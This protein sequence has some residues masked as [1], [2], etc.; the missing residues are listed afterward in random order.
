[1]ENSSKMKKMNFEIIINAPTEKVYHCMLDRPTYKQWTAAFNPTSDYEGSWEKGSDIYFV[2]TNKKGQK[3]GMISRI[4]EN[5]PNKFVS[6]EHL[7]M[8]QDGKEVTSGPEVDPWAGSLENYSF[9]SVNGGT[10]VEV[11]LDTNSEFEAYFED[12]WPKALNK[13]KEICERKN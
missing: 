8:I 10:K 5:I 11:E 6:I 12:S 7:G 1:M 4:K 2:G 9:S 13:L 3:E